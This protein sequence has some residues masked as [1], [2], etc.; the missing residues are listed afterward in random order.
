MRRTAG[1]RTALGV[2]IIIRTEKGFIN[3]R[4]C[5]ERYPE[6][7]KAKKKKCPLMGL[8]DGREGDEECYEYCSGKSEITTIHLIQYNECG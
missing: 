7:K 1:H 4:F 6:S 5:T 8:D 3:L 2:Y